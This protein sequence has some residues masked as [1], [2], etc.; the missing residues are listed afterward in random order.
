MRPTRHHAY[1]PEGVPHTLAPDG[2]TLPQRLEAVAAR[3]PDK[4]AID[5]YGRALSFGDFQRAVLALAGYMQQ[6]LEVRRGD[7]VLLLMQ[8]CPHFC[9]AYYAIL[10]C[11]AVVVAANP[12]S[13]ATELA[14][15]AEDSGARVLLATQEM[16]DRIEPLLA[17]GL[18]SGCVIG[19]CADM[20]GRPEDVPFMQI[21]PFVCE[22]RRP[23]TPVEAQSGM[24]DFAGAIEAG[25]APMPMEVGAEDLAVVGY[26]S[27][28]TGK[29]KGAMLSHRALALVVAQRS[30]WFS[31][32]PDCSDLV[33]LPINHIAGMCAINQALCEGRTM[34]LLSRWDAAAVPA[35]IEQRRIDRWAAVTPMLVELLGRPELAQH[36]IS[37][38][39]RLYGGATAMPESVAREVR[40]RLGVPYIEC[41]GMTETCGS[42]HMNPPQAPRLACGGIPQINVDARV[43][44]PDTGDELG[45]NMRGEI[46]MHGPMQFEGYW[47]K[48]EATREAFIELDGKRFVRSGD[49]GH[50]DEDGYFYITDR[51]KRMINASGLKVWPA[52]IEACLYGHPAVQEACVISAQ[53]ERRGE[54]VKALVVLKPGAGGTLDGDALIAWAR[55]RLAAYKAPRLI[56]FVQSLPKTGA[57]KVM[58]RVLQEQQTERDRRQRDATESTQAS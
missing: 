43:I 35:L 29:P 2:R 25:I 34:V 11:G 50:Y 1:W 54:T 56:E 53:D 15:Y 9:V 36:D 31:G 17:H 57:G 32:S 37:S 42:S 16:Q 51:L 55:K 18:L 38:L 41:Y 30:L 20:A 44:D 52:E 19:A 12:M 26:T 40:D 33:I 21:P 39:K 24:H 7:R 10:R 46:V 3:K 4:T 14:Y 28:T 58:W 49:I 27:G 47:N 13:T 23:I 8:N 48:P 22:A 5:Y 45:P 6:R